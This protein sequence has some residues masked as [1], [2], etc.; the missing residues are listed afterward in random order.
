[1]RYLQAESKHDRKNVVDSRP[2]VCLYFIEPTGH[3][4]S[5]LD[6]LA[7]K[8]IGEKV[9]LIPI[10]SK[11]DLLTKSELEN[12]RANIQ[13]VIQSQNIRVY[14]EDDEAYMESMPFS[15]IASMNMNKRVYPWGTVHVE[16]E[17]HCDFVK[18]RQILVR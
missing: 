4:L 2:H 10:I 16:N 8:D 6:T 1:M 11:A 9:N 3:T 15:V 17:K 13:S 5:Q 7:M 12:F 18:L 14:N